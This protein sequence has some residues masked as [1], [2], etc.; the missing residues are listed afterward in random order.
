MRRC[1]D[2]RLYS[3]TGVDALEGGTG[4]HW[5]EIDR[6]DLATGFAMTLSVG[7][8]VQATASD[9]TT[10]IGVEHS[11]STVAPELTRSMAARGTTTL[12]P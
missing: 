2:D 6:S 11:G 12:L 5:A 3:G 1:D 10:V 4:T 7:P 8:T 9:G